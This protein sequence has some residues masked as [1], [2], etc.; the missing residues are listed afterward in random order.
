MSTLQSPRFTRTFRRRQFDGPRPAAAA[1]SH[2]ALGDA[3]RRFAAVAVRP[4][5]D[6]VD[7]GTGEGQAALLAARVARRVVGI[8]RQARAI[9]SARA[10]AL[11][12]GMPNVE[13][14]RLDLEAAGLLSRD[15]RRRL[16]C[17]RGFDAA[18]AHLCVSG[19]VLRRASALLKPAGRGVITALH[20]DHWHETGRASRFA[21]DERGLVN[22]L[23][24]ARLAP[25]AVEIETT[26]IRFVSL[27]ALR[28]LFLGGPRT[29]RL[30][31]WREDG[32]WGRLQE[33]FRG[34]R[35]TLTISRISA[36]VRRRPRAS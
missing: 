15:L 25:L 8:D 12:L 30:R 36:L 26:E 5:D 3:F 34:G 9:E 2:E 33:R 27:E 21:Y 19:P 17:P 23:R 7:L 28:D 29:R 4:G 10:R 35:R 13:F 18:L 24:A 20:S 22:A 11:A 31:D 16:G 1:A 6:V 32:R 14:H